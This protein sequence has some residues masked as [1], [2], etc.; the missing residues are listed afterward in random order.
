MS[1]TWQVSDSCVEGNLTSAMNLYAEIPQACR[2]N[3][4]S[5]TAAVS[6]TVSFNAGTALNDTVTTIDYLFN[7]TAACMQATGFATVD[8]ASCAGMAQ[9]LVDGALHDTAD[10]VVDAAGC[11]CKAQ[12]LFVRN[13][14]L[15][16]SVS[17]S[18]INYS[19]ESYPLDFCV[20]GGALQARQ[21]TSEL[22]ATI[23]FN[24]TRV[25]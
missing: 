6:G 16:Y 14:S 7:P 25:N 5:V 4:E 20:Q 13:E 11:T 22:V 10:C 21:F 24:A 9:A 19:G 15:T 12:N 23:F 1:G 3:Y 17:G 2:G 18:A 8:D